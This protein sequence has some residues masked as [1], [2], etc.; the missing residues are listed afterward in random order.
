MLML[1]LCAVALVSVGAILRV[2]PVRALLATACSMVGAGLALGAVVVS[3]VAGCSASAVR[4]QRTA[5]ASTATIANRTLDVLLGPEG[6]APLAGEYARIQRRVAL[7]AC[8]YDPDELDE[9]RPCPKDSIEDAAAAVMKVREQWA[10]VWHVWDL[11][12]VAHAAWHAQL[13]RCE[14]E[15]ADAGGECTVKLEQLAATVVQHVV[16]VRCALRGLGAP[17][18]FPG[19]VACGPDKVGTDE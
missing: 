15:Q 11:A 17:D 10:I 16:A 5:A 18:P 12:S 4:A 7:A 3:C 1:M 14:R 9:V 6:R 2:R 13:D 19:S 8:G